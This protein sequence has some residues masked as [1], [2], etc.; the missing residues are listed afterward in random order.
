MCTLTVNERTYLLNS[1]KNLLDEY[2]YEYSTDALNSILDEWVFN[3]STLIEAFKKHPNYVDGKFLIAFDYNYERGFDNSVFRRFER[4]IDMVIAYVMDKGFSAVSEITDDEIKDMVQRLEERE[5][6][7]SGVSIMSPAFQ[8][9]LVEMAVELVQIGGA[10]DLLKY[11]TN[12]V[13]IG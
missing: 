10:M 8:G 2:D 1:M 4:Y 7:S 9:W 12:E 3:K 13:F 6:N 11:V 5:K